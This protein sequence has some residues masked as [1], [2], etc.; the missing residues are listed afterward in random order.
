MARA[1]DRRSNQGSSSPIEDGNI[2][3]AAGLFPDVH[4]AKDAVV[5]LKAAGF[6]D[7]EIGLAMRSPSNTQGST[8]VVTGTR[9]TEEA[10]TGAVGGGVLGGLAGLLVAAGV[11]AIPGVG[12]LLAGGSLA[13]M[14][15]ST[16]AS[17]AAGAGVGAT[18]GGLVGA[19]VGF[20]IPEVDA[21]HF[22]TAVRSGRVLVLV[23][24]PARIS[25]ALAI[26]QRHGGETDVGGK[27]PSSDDPE[28]L[29]I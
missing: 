5:E 19:L 17:I 26:L 23:K 8:D 12:S 21:R 27:R 4:T 3:I 9:A 28:T 22:E 18:A 10:A 25:D 7:K 2:R 11:V 15:G 24:T 6:T 1:E 16:G 13:S 20:D 14:L 29:L